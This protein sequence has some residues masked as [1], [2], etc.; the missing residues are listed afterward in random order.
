MAFGNVP[1]PQSFRWKSVHI[2]FFSE[3]LVMWW[4][5]HEDIQES[6]DFL[7]S[8]VW[9]LIWPRSALWLV[10]TLEAMIFIKLSRLN[11]LGIELRRLGQRALIILISPVLVTTDFPFPVLTLLCIAAKSSLHRLTPPPLL[12][13]SLSIY[14]FSSILIPLSSQLKDSLSWNL[15]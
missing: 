14:F 6:C 2:S 5:S 11:L 10:S 4:R 8:S 15:I 13:H 7:Q 12:L 1:M 3:M 9:L